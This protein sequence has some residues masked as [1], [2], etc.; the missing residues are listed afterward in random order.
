MTA[1]RSFIRLL[2]TVLIVLTVSLGAGTVAAATAPAVSYRAHT[3]K[4][5]WMNIVRNGAT[6]GTTGQSLRM[7]AIQMRI[8]DSSISGGITYRSYVQKSGWE[9]SWK[10][11]GGLSG[12]TGKSL[13]IE[14][15]QIK[16]TGKLADKYEV[17]Y[18][19]YSQG[20]GWLGW[21]KN[22]A[23]AGTG[24]YNYRAEAIQIRLVKK[25]GAAPGSTKNAYR[26]KLAATNTNRYWVTSNY[27]YNTTQNTLGYYKTLDAAKKAINAKPSST[28][29]QWFVYDRT[30]K[31]V[32]YPAATTKAKKIQRAV[33]WAK[34]IA[35]D[36]KH[37]YDRTGEWLANNLDLS[38]SGN[39]RFGR[40]GNYSCSPL[41]EMA[42]ELSGYIN[43]RSVVKKKSIRMSADFG[44]KI[45]LNSTSLAKALLAS[46]SFTEVTTSFKKSGVSAL[47][48]GDIVLQ[49]NERHCGLYVGNGMV[50]EARGKSKGI[51]V[52]PFRTVWGRVFRPKT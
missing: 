15:I 52:N 23:S 16:L 45:G 41:V 4:N 7:E 43:L 25:G 18:R 37:G 50:A 46:G 20:F 51:V 39:L 30:A 17:Y 48:P 40:Y 24:N 29:A 13:R 26:T 36:N 9:K 27:F 34:A 38:N 12:T 28:R 35:N 47:K 6:A 32:V 42:F 31:K 14:A 5:G 8:R 22:G 21:A 33:A 1:K 19:V 49:T 2:F 11:N 3:Q 44:K 10:Y